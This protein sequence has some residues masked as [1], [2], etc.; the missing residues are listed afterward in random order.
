MAWIEVRQYAPATESGN[1][2]YK[3]V[4]KDRAHLTAK[5]KDHEV[6]ITTWRD[7]Y[8]EHQM[9][10]CKTCGETHHCMIDN[11]GYLATTGDETLG[12]LRMILLI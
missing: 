5:H 2:I 4:V 6:V 9:I 11:R 7:K 8:G 10:G 1:A 3:G 12:S